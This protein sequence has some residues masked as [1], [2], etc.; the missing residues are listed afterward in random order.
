VS[1]FHDLPARAKLYIGLVT[2]LGGLAV[3]KSVYDLY[4]LG[5]PSQWF[6]L[7]GLTLLS[8]SITVKVPSVPS[9]ISASETFVF[10]SV[11]L[12]GTAAGTV[13][14]A[15]DGVG[16]IASLW[17][18]HRPRLPFYKTLFNLAA[19]SLAIWV[20][21]GIRFQLAGVAPLAGSPVPIS[22]LVMPLFGFTVLYFLFNSWLIAG[23]ISLTT[24]LSPI[25][26]WRNNFLWLSVNYF[27]GA[28][29]AA[30]LVAYTRNLDLMALGIIVPLVVISY[31]TLKTS[32][33]RVEDALKHLTELNKL[34]LSTIETLAM[35]IDAK[36]QI[37]HGHIRR[38]QSL[39]VS[40]AGRLG[41]KDQSLIKAIEAASLLHDM[42]KLAVPEY[43]LNKPG[44]LTSG[45]FQKM[46]LHASVGADIL[47][48][49]DFPYPVVPVV[50][51]HHEHWDGSG[52][53]DGLKGTEIP[54]GARILA[55]V[56]CFDALT[57][58]RPYRPHVPR[59]AALE[60]LRERR[61]TM[62]DPWVV[63]TFIQVYQEIAPVEHQAASYKEALTE[64]AKSSQQP[65]P[66]MVDAVQD[67]GSGL[68]D[69]VGLYSLARAVAGSGG[70]HDAW[71]HVAAYV[72]NMAPESVIV[73]YA[74][75]PSRDELVATC[76][77][78][79]STARLEG[80]RIPLGQRISGWVAANRQT[81]L[82]A[83]PALDLEERIGLIAPQPRS[84]LSAALFVERHLVGVLTVYSPAPDAFSDEDVRRLE[85]IARHLA[86]PLRQ[87]IEGEQLQAVRG[88]PAA[89]SPQG[90]ELA[91]FETAAAQLACPAT[92]LFV[93][94][95]DVAASA[96]SSTM[97]EYLAATIRS[98]L[99]GADT[100]FRYGG[101][102]FVV[103]LMETDDPTIEAISRRIAAALC[104]A[105]GSSRA[106]AGI[107]PRIGAAS[108]PTDGDTLTGLIAAAR[109][110]A[111]IGPAEA[112]DQPPSETVH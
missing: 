1:S 79:A 3:T 26:V 10:T 59:E 104:A 112:G 72:S 84:A 78:G 53:P 74:S 83:D 29:V 101:T 85:A 20:A 17:L 55:V 82:N 18:L 98:A 64:I 13:T 77:H 89:V 35:A 41:V 47:T 65:A 5:I 19:P 97:L 7:A 86:H 32:M 60:V 56:D 67:L 28:S 76:T 40:L 57:S 75:E 36:D 22:S 88:G 6:L 68:H 30:L 23:A 14:V 96:E 71:R 49:I 11:L 33:G 109:R 95:P 45:E 4:A 27:G 61:G 90:A 37:T 73:F 94:V 58:D 63:D 34:Y 16:L 31:L 46:K 105:S 38:V 69:A 93:D 91:A 103:F 48:A 70:L 12:F 66:T 111:R 87:T 42:G 99:R 9:H 39:A 21:G 50:R 110:R 106:G 8:G 24:R 44:R 15:L 108:A 62:Y 54:L 102:Q 51:H 52:Y 81:I 100:V 25:T 80:L 107:E 43:I 92:V 2:V